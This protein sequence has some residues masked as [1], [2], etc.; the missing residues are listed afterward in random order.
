M[1]TTNDTPQTIQNKPDNA[2]KFL[3]DEFDPALIPEGATSYVMTTVWTDMSEENDA[4]AVHKVY[5]DGAPDGYFFV[6]KVGPHGAREAKR[7]IISK[8]EYDQAII[9]HEQS[10]A[11]KRRTEFTLDGLEMKFDEY[12]D[13]PLHIIEV[14]AATPEAREAF[15]PGVF[16]WKLHEI[17]DE[18]YDGYR[19]LKH[20][21]QKS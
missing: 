2:R 21:P 8:A 4:K 14:D 15:D 18:S 1:V 9:G 6:E 5:D 7:R 16:P 20:L 10:T 13:G 19:V 11:R 3:V 12:L 17:F